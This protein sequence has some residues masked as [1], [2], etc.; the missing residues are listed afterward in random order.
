MWMA[1]LTRRFPRLLSRLTL[2]PPA[3]G[4]L[5]GRGA[6]VGGEAVAVLE[7]GHVADLADDGGGD[8]R[9]D[10]EQAGQAGPAGPDG[11]VEFLPGL[12]QLGVDA[13]Q[14]LD[15]RRGELAARGR[16]GTGRRDRAKQAGGVR[17]DDLLRDAAG[18]QLAEHRVQPAGNLRAAA[19]QVTAALGPGLQHRRVVVGPGL[20]D[21]GRAQRRHRDGPGVVGV[22]LVHVPGGEQPDPRAQLG[23][24]VEDPLAGGQEL[25]G[26]Q[27]PQAAGAFH[28]PGPLRPGRGP[29]QQPPG[30]HGTGG[31]PQLAQRLLGPADRHCRVRGFVRVHPDHNSCHD[32]SSSRMPGENRSGHA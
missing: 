13:A 15:E 20:A 18:N 5:N 27:V 1:W 30:L 11:G 32:G 21:A 3:R 17:C 26:Q 31:H 29:C 12:A 16:D 9:P 19:G 24:H 23:L 2:R 8:D 7:A 28:G 25:L 6:V 22:V 10:A 4:D 14:V